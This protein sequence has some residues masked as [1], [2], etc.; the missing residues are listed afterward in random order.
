MK[1]YHYT[2]LDTL[3]K[4][5]CD[6]EAENNPNLCFWATYYKNM[7]DPSEYDFGGYALLRNLSNIENE[8]R[9]PPHQSFGFFFFCNPHIIDSIIKATNENPFS[10]TISEYPFVIQEY[11]YLISFSENKDSIPMWGMYGG[12]GY[13][14]SLGFNKEKLTCKAKTIQDWPAG[15]E[16]IRCLYCNNDKESAVFPEEEY[17]VCRD[18]YRMLINDTMFNSMSLIHGI[19]N[20]TQQ[21]L[22]PVVVNQLVSEMVRFIGSKTKNLQYDY[23]R[24][25]RLLI[26]NHEKD[27]IE[28]RDKND[29]LKEIPYISVYIPFDA[30][31]EIIIG[32]C[33]NYEQSRKRVEAIL[34]DIG[35]SLSSVSII[36]SSAPYRV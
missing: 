9:I 4:M 33:S 36:K 16:L 19:E 20:Y 8:L 12:N 28:Y 24:E 10:C 22:Q 21:P 3:N 2:Q 5:L 18:A 34:L 29:V 13:G 27:A 7:N 26:G 1:L 23:E 25:W 6:F 32:P 35:I 14:I 15:S 17:E 11:S 31:E 30:L